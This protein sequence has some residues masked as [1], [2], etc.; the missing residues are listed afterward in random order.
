MCVFLEIIFRFVGSPLKVINKTSD[1]QFNLNYGW[2]FIPNS[3]YES[4]GFKYKIN[5]LGLYSPEINKEKKGLRIAYLGDSYTIGPGI[6]FYDNYPFL[7]TENLEKKL[8]KN[9]DFLIGGIQGSSP[10]Q[11]E[12]IYKKKIQQYNP[13]VVVY[14]L[15]YNDIDDDYIFNFSDYHAR[16]Q[17]YSFVPEILRR[18]RFVQRLIV[19]SSSILSKYYSSVYQEDDAS[20][21][22]TKKLKWDKY[23]IPALDKMLNQ[24]RQH[25]TKFVLFY[26]PVGWEFNNEYEAN[27]K[28]Q[29]RFFIYKVA[30]EWAKK[31]NVPY[32]DMYDT[33]LKNNTEKTNELYLPADKGSHLTTL[34]TS[35]I[36]EELTSMLLK[37]NLK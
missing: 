5:S 19:L 6:G 32:I 18:S 30:G 36:T 21:P 35:L 3:Q 29:K 24:A 17:V 27:R 16:M 28:A 10:T 7:V 2:E 37:L 23:T 1:I 25:K 14:E 9:I 12:E 4:Y 15:F 22:I 11:Q 26:I 13:D 33:F 20:N 31:N 34:G 8:N